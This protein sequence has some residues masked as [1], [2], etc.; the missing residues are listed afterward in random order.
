MLLSARY[1]GEGDRHSDEEDVSLD[2]VT[3]SCARVLTT[4][5]EEDYDGEFVEIGKYLSTLQWDESWSTKDFHRIQKKAYKYFLEDGALWRHAK[6][7]N[8]TLMQVLCKLED[9]RKLMCEFHDS[10]WAGHRGIWVTF[11]KLKEKYY[12]QEFTRL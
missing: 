12:G 8:G 10:A 9:R 4:F 3:S 6:K 1:N 11:T 2:F 7:K 5:V